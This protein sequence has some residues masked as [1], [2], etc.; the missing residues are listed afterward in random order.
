MLV[1]RIETE[2]IRLKFWSKSFPVY[3]TQV[4]QDFNICYIY[5]L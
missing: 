3:Y 5:K 1:H 2:T 4:K